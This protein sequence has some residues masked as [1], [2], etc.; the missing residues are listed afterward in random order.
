VDVPGVQPV[1]LGS[2]PAV[3]A[4]ATVAPS[5]CGSAAQGAAPTRAHRPCLVERGRHAPASILVSTPVPQGARSARQ[6]PLTAAPR[7]APARESGSGPR[8]SVAWSRSSVD[9]PEVLPSACRGTA[10]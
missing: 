4:P 8:G 7:G 9:Y 5:V 2:R 6:R 10:G 3:L 1:T